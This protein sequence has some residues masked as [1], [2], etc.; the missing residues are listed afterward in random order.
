[1]Y[2]FWRDYFYILSVRLD[3]NKWESALYNKHLG[4]RLGTHTMYFFPIINNNI[5]FL[6]LEVYV[7]LIQTIQYSFLL[8]LGVYNVPTD[9]RF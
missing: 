9:K 3:H 2:T 4:I 8:L 6:V 7:R 5:S 1:M